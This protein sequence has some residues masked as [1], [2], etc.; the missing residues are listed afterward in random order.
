MT[1]SLSHAPTVCFFWQGYFFR[2]FLRDLR[3]F[4]G[5]LQSLKEGGGSFEFFVSVFLE[6][7]LILVR[8]ED[9][10]DDHSQLPWGYE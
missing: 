2:Y 6:R 7:N 9:F 10:L 5:V 4:E 8:D 3:R 1:L